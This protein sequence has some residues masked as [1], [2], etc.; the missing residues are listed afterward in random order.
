VPLPPPIIRNATRRRYVALIVAVGVVG[1]VVSISLYRYSYK[2]ERDRIEAEFGLRAEA[3]HALNREIL[4][5]YV[6]AVFALKCLFEGSEEVNRGE[7]HRVATDIL[8]RYSGITA[9]EW[10]PVVTESERGA[11]EQRAARE[12]GRLFEFTEPAADGEMIRALYRPEH[13]PILYL[14]PLTGN[15]KAL[16][17][18]LKIAP[19]RPFLEHAR[20]TRQ[21]VASSQFALIQHHS[22]LV[23]TWPVFVK[24]PGEAAERKFEGFVQGVFRIDEILTKTNPPSPTRTID[25]LFIDDSAESASQRL[26]YQTQLARDASNQS[27][28]IEE[29]F[30]QGLHR[31]FSMEIGGRQWLAWY[32]PSAAWLAEQ[33]TWTPQLWLVS[34][35]VIT[36]LLASLLT[37]IARRTAAIQNEVDDRTRDLSESRRQLSSLLHALPGM[38]YRCRFEDQLSVIFV[39]E[40]VL[41]LTGYEADEL[42]SG[43]IHFRDLIHPADVETARMATRRALQARDDVE[44][45]YR[46]RTAAGVEKWILSRGRGVVGSDGRLLFEGL[47]IDI[48]DRKRAE[49]DNLMIE[50]RLLETQK[51]ESV[52]LLAGGIA[53]DFNNLLAGVLGNANLARL[54]LGEE[55]SVTDHLIKIETGISRAADLCQQMLAYSGRGQLVIGT[56]DLTELVRDTLPLLQGTISSQTTIRLDLSPEPTLV[57]ADTT[58]LRQIAMNL[59]INASD[60]LGEAGGEIF[61]ATGR[62]WIDRAFLS[63]AR[64]GERIPP[65]DYVFM[66]IRDTGCGMSPT[67]ISKVFDPFFTTKF[68]GRG[69]G[70]SAVLGIVRGHGGALR[71]ESALSRGSTF[72]LILPVTAKPLARVSNPP[73]D[74]PWHGEGRVLVID[75]EA[76]VREVASEL[77]RSFGFEVVAAVGGNDGI[78]LFRVDPAGFSAVLLDLTMPGMNGQETLAILR[79]IDPDVR[80]ILASGYGSHD[81]TPDLSAGD[82]PLF[83]Q[84]PF[85]RSQLEQKLKEIL[86]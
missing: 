60:A 10:V 58:Q 76:P 74:Q 37:A 8:S 54:K 72:T 82:A 77:I 24:Y 13:Y 81:H 34:G 42:I 83:L 22:G 19:T 85:T 61:I 79:S 27:G 71:V 78:N 68:S 36:A 14:E 53:H 59:I 35:L 2:A 70:L 86:A 80:V 12:M 51:L 31:Q 56:V 23:M 5:N 67:T 6:S 63:T 64:F 32:R 41:A 21:L 4:S 65:G 48:T 9:V 84:K 45:E 57:L 55:S 44:V 50:R 52:G 15:E 43:R 30:K 47:A 1:L 29:N 20:E 69:L 11:V 7:F 26:L 17:Y 38:A 28:S 66:E 46:I 25:L 49:A 3:R 18:D 40:G 33:Q 75:D 39:S 16:G 73:F 62:R